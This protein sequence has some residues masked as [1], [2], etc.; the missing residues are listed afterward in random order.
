MDPTLPGLALA[1]L[2]GVGLFALR[3]FRKSRQRLRET[4]GQLPAAD[5]CLRHQT[6]G[7]PLMQRCLADKL[8]DVARTLQAAQQEH[9]VT[10]QQLEAAE[11][12]LVSCR[13][14]IET[15]KCGRC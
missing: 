11:Q 7:S 4:E 13:M 6:T 15:L 1:A 14:E 10:L 3:R 9:R 8:Q 12:K 5:S 2:A